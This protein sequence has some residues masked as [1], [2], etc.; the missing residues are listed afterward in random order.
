MATLLAADDIAA[1]LDDAAAMAEA[2]AELGYV[3]FLRARYDRAEVWLSQARDL[4]AGDPAV[5]AK[6]TTYLGSVESDRADYVSALLHLA[7]G[8]RLAG[9]AGDGRRAAY[10]AGDARPR[11]PAPG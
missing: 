4:G 6:A 9:L 1:G 10:A 8:R 3:D 11:P 5:A 7:E 2:R